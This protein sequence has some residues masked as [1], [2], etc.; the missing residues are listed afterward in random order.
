MIRKL[1]VKAEHK[2]QRVKVD[3]LSAVL[4]WLI[5][6]CMGVGGLSSLI[7]C[8]TNGFDKLPIGACSTN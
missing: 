2:T 4:P 8:K 5:G 3:A 1:D 7:D 6:D